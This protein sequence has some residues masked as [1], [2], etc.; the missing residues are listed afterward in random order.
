[1]TTTI[2]AAAELGW[3][4]QRLHDLARVSPEI[5]INRQGCGGHHDPNRWNMDALRLTKLI[6]ER[7]DVPLTTAVRLAV[8]ADYDGEWT[9][10]LTVPD[11]RS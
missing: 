10:T 7:F 5:A 2:D 1:M 8:H 11:K 4:P 9:I 6:A 3:K